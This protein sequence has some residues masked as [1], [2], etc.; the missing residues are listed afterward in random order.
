MH[1]FRNIALAMC[2][3]SIVA[4]D[5]AAQDRS[6]IVGFWAGVVERSGKVWNVEMNA[7]VTGG[8]LQT[9]ITF[10][11][12]DVPDVPFPVK[13]T[14]RGFRLERPQPGGHPI[15]FD[16]VIENDAFAGKWA[17]FG[18]EGKFSMNRSTK[19]D[20][21]YREEEVVFANGDIKLAGTLLIPLAAGKH[22]AVVITHGSFPNERTTYRSWG[23]RFAEAG[24]AALIYDKRGSGK[25]TGNTRAA[26]MENLA[27]DALAG[28][29]LLKLR[30]DVDGAKIGVAGHSQGGWIAPLAAVR[31]RDVAFVIASGAAAVTP[32]EQSIYHRAGVMRG[33]GI[34]DNEIEQASRLRQ[35]LYHLNRLILAGEPYQKERAAIS[36]ELMASKDARWFAPAELPPQLAG[37]L[38][39]LG[40]LELLFFDPTDVWRSL[41]VPVLVLWGDKDTV[42]PV[43]K[44]RAII[45]RL[46]TKAGNK[47]LSVKVFEGVDH[48]NNLVRNG[49]DWDFPR[50][51]LDY[52]RS[53][54]EW[55]RNVV[56]QKTKSGEI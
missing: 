52:N 53:M 47:H 39:P 15:V 14:E 40:A 37:E 22:P 31:S 10:V 13:R 27:D 7:A 28:V 38:P 25:S 9:S 26:S 46:Q 21:G 45:E 56:S 17:G 20:V 32:A 35:R 41:K 4:G 36:Q 12:L 29:R 1:I 55:A 42:V 5:I 18:V 44:S 34:T 8:E 49:D 6:P 3:I 33:Q 16:G 54:I 51:S 2:A 48:G 11:D 24:I 50:V 23:R 30:S 19:P 43:V